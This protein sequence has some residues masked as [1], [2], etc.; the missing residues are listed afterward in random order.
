MIVVPAKRSE[1]ENGESPGLPDQFT[2]ISQAAE[3]SF[4]WLVG[5]KRI[6][7]GPPRDRQSF[8]KLCINV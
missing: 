6:F 5:N 4:S 3:L 1:R 7:E 8:S 2:H